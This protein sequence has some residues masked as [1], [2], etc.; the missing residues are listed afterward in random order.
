MKLIKEESSFVLGK[1]IKSRRNYCKVNILENQDEFDIWTKDSV[2]NI[3]M[4]VL[5]RKCK[6]KE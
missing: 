1:V 3:E 6:W 2:W 4:G 5:K